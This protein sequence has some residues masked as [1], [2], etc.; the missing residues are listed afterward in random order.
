MKKIVGTSKLS[1]LIFFLISLVRY[2][3]NILTHLISQSAS[4]TTSTQLLIIILHPIYT[5]LRRLALLLC[6]FSILLGIY[7]YLLYIQ[8][9]QLLVSAKWNRTYLGEH[10]TT[11]RNTLCHQ[12]KNHNTLYLPNPG[13]SLFM[14]FSVASSIMALI[15]NFAFR[16]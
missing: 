10:T 14:T 1:K 5:S 3:S 8:T 16:T 12:R 9:T 7:T 4:F 15:I 6:S 2:L 11:Y 13:Q